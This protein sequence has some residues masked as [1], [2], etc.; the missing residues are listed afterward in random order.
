VLAGL[1]G[2]MRLL[3]AQA[4]TRVDDSITPD[5]PDRAAARSEE[6]ERAP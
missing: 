4:R 1:G 2:I 3:V 5:A 6:T